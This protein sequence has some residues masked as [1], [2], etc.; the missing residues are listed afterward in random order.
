MSASYKDI[1]IGPYGTTRSYVNNINQ[2]AELGSMNNTQT[3]FVS[4]PPI[5]SET[6]FT[7]VPAWGRDGF[8]SNYREGSNGYNTLVNA[9]CCEGQACQQTTQ[10]L[11]GDTTNLVKAVYNQH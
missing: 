4:G 7:I 3:N 11:F 5:P 1:S 9:Y 2:Y 6:R 8:R 10:P